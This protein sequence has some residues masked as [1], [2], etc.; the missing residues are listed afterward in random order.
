MEIVAEVTRPE[1]PSFVSN[2]SDRR[3][4]DS[5]P[6]KSVVEKRGVAGGREGGREWQEE[7]AADLG[8][9]TNI[10][11]QIFPDCHP[12]PN[13]WSQRRQQPHVCKKS[14]TFY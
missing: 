8:G 10:K 4:K 12:L 3:Y 2:I 11:S 14:P 9:N 6:A 7:M 5:P 1:V 13:V